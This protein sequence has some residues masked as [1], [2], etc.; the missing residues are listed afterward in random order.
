MNVGLIRDN[1]KQGFYTHVQL[2]Q[3]KCSPCGVYL[4]LLFSSDCIKN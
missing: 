4:C 3:R 1:M 2:L